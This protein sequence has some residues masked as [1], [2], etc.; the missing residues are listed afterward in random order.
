MD[1]KVDYRV[2]KCIYNRGSECCH[3]KEI[4]ISGNNVCDSD[5][6][7]CESFK[8]SGTTF[9]AI[10]NLKEEFKPRLE[11]YCD[12]N[13]CVFH[14]NGFLNGKCNRVTITLDENKGETRCLSYKMM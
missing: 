4:M 3:K 2:T 12:V 6:T 10:H 9:C 7:K 5:D 11:V 14:S 13:N 1:K 8:D